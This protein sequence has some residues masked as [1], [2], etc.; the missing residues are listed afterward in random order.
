[1]TTLES[2]YKTLDESNNFII[3]KILPLNEYFSKIFL[4]LPSR[5]SGPF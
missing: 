4:S 3:F 5:P 2:N 1:M